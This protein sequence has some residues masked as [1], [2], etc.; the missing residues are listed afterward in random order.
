MILGMARKQHMRPFGNL[1]GDMEASAKVSS[2]DLDKVYRD[3]AKKGLVPRKSPR[4]Y[5]ER[6]ERIYG[7]LG[8]VPGR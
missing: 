5:F 6:N 3:L 7:A 2:A 1:M 8:F 4:S